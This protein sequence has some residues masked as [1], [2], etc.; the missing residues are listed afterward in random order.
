M[1]KN[2]PHLGS[3]LDDFLNEE[4][5]RDE[6]DV[7]AARKVIAVSLTDAM[8]R[9]NITKTEFARRM[10][11]SRAVVNRILDPSN[12][13]L[14]FKNAARASKALGKKLKIEMVDA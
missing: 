10:G 9:Q 1:K 4:G 5:I 11:T 3:S 14:T 8:I 13:S 7:M 2:N 6:V 12:P